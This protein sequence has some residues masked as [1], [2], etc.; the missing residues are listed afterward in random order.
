M[1]KHVEVSDMP[2]PRQPTDVIKAKGAK[3]LTQAEEDA[4]RD[5][6]VHVPPPERAEPPKWLGKKFHREFREIGEI[7]RLAGL[8]TDLDRDVLGQFLVA[9]ERWQRADRLASAA[10]RQKDEKLAREWTGIQSTYFKQCRQCAEA[11]GLSVSSRCR[12]VVREVLATA[13]READ[14]ADEFTRALRARQARAMGE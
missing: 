6:E 9:R 8:Y 14:E 11:M 7:L 13:A 10:I 3:H 2:G 4:R 5:Q 12:L 1:P